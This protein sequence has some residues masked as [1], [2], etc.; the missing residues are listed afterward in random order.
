[1]PFGDVSRPLRARIHFSAECL[2]PDDHVFTRRAP[3]QESRMDF[4]AA[5]ISDSIMAPGQPFESRFRGL[6]GYRSG[7]RWLCR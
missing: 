3:M 5:V 1:M 2:D 7:G 6:G 4:A